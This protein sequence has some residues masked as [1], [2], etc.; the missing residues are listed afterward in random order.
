[1]KRT[2]IHTWLVAAP[3]VLA[4]L[5]MLFINPA[6]AAAFN[7]DKR[8]KMGV[9]LGAPQKPPRNQQPGGQSG[10]PKLT[11]NGESTVSDIKIYTFANAPV[12][13]VRSA[14]KPFTLP[15]GREHWYEAVYLPQSGVNWV[16]AKHLAKEAGGYL[17][18]IHS[19]EENNFVFSLIDDPKFWHKWDSSHNYVQSGPFIGGYKPNVSGRSK[20]GWKWISGEPWDYANWCKDGVPGDRDP[21]PNDQPNNATGNQDIVAFGEVTDRVPYWGD[22]PHRFGSYNDSHGSK[23]YGFIIEYEKKP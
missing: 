22:F 19:P 11:N 21:R 20:S 15:D 7:K 4:A 12:K 16:Q 18:S 6:P 10:S 2:S 1:M 9:P 23:A 14:P 8:R 13:I 3:L 5:G 17:V